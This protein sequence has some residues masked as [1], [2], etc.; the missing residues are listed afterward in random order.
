MTS[1]PYRLVADA[2]YFGTPVPVMQQ[3]NVLVRV[4][5]QLN[6]GRTAPAAK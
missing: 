1:A 3:W 4:T 6:W 2:G 5:K